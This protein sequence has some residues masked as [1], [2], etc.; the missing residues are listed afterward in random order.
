MD[1]EN[2]NSKIVPQEFKAFCKNSTIFHKNPAKSL[3]EFHGQLLWSIAYKM[4]SEYF[5]ALCVKKHMTE[6]I[7]NDSFL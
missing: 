6:D 4:T 1:I 2:S 5:K 7:F 3:E